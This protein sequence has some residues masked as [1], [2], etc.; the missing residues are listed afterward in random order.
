[1]PSRRQR[2]TAE[3]LKQGPNPYVEVPASISTTFAEYSEKGRI[4]VHGT[5]EGTEI[6]GNLVPRSG[7]H[8]L[9]LHAGMR[10]A[11]GVGLG[12]TVELVLRATPWDHVPTPKDVEAALKKSGAQAAFEAKSPSQRHELLRWVEVAESAAERAKRVAKF[13]VGVQGKTEPEKKGQ[14]AKRLRP[15]WTCPKC[16]HVFVNTNQFHSCRRYTLEQ[17]FAKSE[18][19][20]RQLFERLRAMVESVGPVHM[21]AYRDQVAFLVRVRF[22]F[23]TPKK[24]WLDVGFWLPRR[25][26]SARFRK[27]ETL[28]PTDHVHILR[29]TEEDQLDEEVMGWVREGYAVGEQKH[30]A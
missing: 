4:R 18:P 7:G 21:Q 14:A 29:V 27:V 24:E 17:T 23:A 25:I 1:M 30:L 22:L 19:Q 6:R 8:W 20:V 15:L 5:L 12:D 28:T 16:G 26:D 2:F 10:A 9:F 11:A 3:I 13:V